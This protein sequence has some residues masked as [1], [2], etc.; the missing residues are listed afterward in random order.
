M[1]DK[2]YFSFNILLHRI[3][4]NI[5]RLLFIGFYKNDLNNRCYINLLS[6]DLINHIIKF[7]GVPPIA[8]KNE[9]NIFELEI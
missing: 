3:S 2:N 5:I 4:W 8:N 1:Q 9:N 7:M 6:N